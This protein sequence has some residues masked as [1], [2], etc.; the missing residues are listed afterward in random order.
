MR[1]IQSKILFVVIS[2]LFVITAIVTTISVSVAHDIIHKDADRILN[3][4]SQKEAAY[5]NEMLNSFMKSSAIMEHYAATELQAADSLK[6]GEYLNR[7]TEKIHQM[8]TEVA[9]N[10]PGTKAFY[11][12]YAPGITSVS[13]GFYSK[14]Q[15]DGSVYELSTEEFVKLSLISAEQAAEYESALRRTGGVWMEPHPSQFSKETVI[16]YIVPIYCQDVFVGILGFNMD[17]DYLISRINEIT[18]YERGYAVLMDRNKEECYNSPSMVEYEEAYANASTALVNDMVLE[19]RAPYKDVQS[20][21]RPM[22]T[23]IVIAFSMVLILAI[24]YTI[25]VTHKIVTPL[26]KLTAA[27]ATISS[28]V[29]DVNFVVDSKDEVGILS[30]VLGETYGKI[31]EY[32]TYIKALAY[33]DSLTGLKNS[34]AYAEAIAEL[35]KEINVGNPSFGVLVADLNHLKRTNDTYGHDV[36]NELISRTAK[37]MTEIFK[38][39]MV[40]RIGGDEFVV[41]LTGSDLENYRTLVDKLDI[42]LSDRYIS[43]KDQYVPISVARGVAVFDPSVDLVYTDVF[44]KA[45]HAMYLNKEAMKAGRI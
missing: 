5:I 26:K 28:G 14:L 4:V 31:M 19:L 33:R 3:N 25:F 18:V 16:S 40:Y 30:Q 36:G 22:L 42:I 45:D 2:A 37:C 23:S 32:S 8:F 6:D 12:C 35:N 34:T 39:S 11:L 41:I 7:Y 44:A 38:T 27:A 20:S 1:S 29:Q 15:N 17:F 21:I 10:T 24:L 43:V 9:V 13:D